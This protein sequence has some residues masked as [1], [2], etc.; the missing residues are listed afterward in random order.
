[1]TGLMT[2][3]KDMHGACSA[4]CCVYEAGDAGVADDI[5]SETC[6]RV[7]SSP[8]DR[9]QPVAEGEAPTLTRSVPCSIQEYASRHASQLVAKSGSER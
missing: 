4:S 3:T 2:F 8:D 9:A 5:T 7:W 6:V 1:M